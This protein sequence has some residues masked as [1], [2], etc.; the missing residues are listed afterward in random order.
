MQCFINNTLFILKPGESIQFRQAAA[1]IGKPGEITGSFTNDFKGELNTSNRALIGYADSLQSDNDFYVEKKVS[2]RLENDRGAEIARGY[3]Q[4][5]EVDERGKSI[6]ITFFGG[7]TPWI[8]LLKGK[9]IRDIWLWDLQHDWTVANISAS[10][11]NTSGYIYPFIDYGRLAALGTASTNT[12]D[13][14]PGVYQH[15]LVQR[16]MERIG[17]KVSGNV[18]ESFKYLKTVIPFTNDTF[19]EDS[20]FQIP[21]EAEKTTTTGYDLTATPASGTSDSSTEVMDFDTI[22]TDELGAFDTALDRYIATKTLSDAVFVAKMSDTL[23]KYVTSSASSTVGTIS[24]A[25]RKNGTDVTNI[26]L[27][28]DTHT[29]DQTTQETDDYTI[30]ATMDL[31][32]TDYVDVVIYFSYSNAV[33]ST[34]IIQL[35]VTCADFNFQLV[36]VDPEI[37]AGGNVTLHNNLPDIDQAEFM[38]D[39]IME[40]NALV[41]TDPFSQTLYINAIENITKQGADAVDWSNRVNG[42]DISYKKFNEIV[43]GYGKKSYFRRLTPTEDD[44]DLVTYNTNNSVPF[45]DGKL[46]IDNDFIQGEVDIYQSP[47]S[48]SYMIWAFAGGSTEGVRA[49]FIP[50]FDSS[51]DKVYRSTPKK[52]LVI[53]DTSVGDFNGETGLPISYIDI[54]GGGAYAS[55]AFAYFTKPRCNSDLDYITDTLAFDTPT[56]INSPDEGLLAKN[57]AAWLRILQKPRYVSL[58]IK[59]WEHQFSNLDLKELVQL[60]TPETRGQFLIDE[61]IFGGT[62]D[63][64]RL[65]Q[66]K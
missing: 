36:S 14:Y 22:V 46:E 25:I 57:Y 29:G 16:M 66:V 51:G 21:A 15:T 58:G 2:A 49:P 38:K 18:I 45:G 20:E 59:L 12:T 4:V 50:R 47:F 13:W 64:V 35:L 7:N 19:E 34:T 27:L 9:S 30:S 53:P 24:W 65:I 37:A 1:T 40:F 28:T 54:D 62:K 52:L 55:V 5:L 6:T 41:T 39:I 33:A 48:A 63:L 60:D 3:V 23:L 26:T 32:S 43:S 11:S 10:W 42:N 44:I 17:W 61:I 56:G 31:V 8:D